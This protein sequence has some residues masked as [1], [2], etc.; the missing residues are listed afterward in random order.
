[1]GKKKDE[2]ISNFS[3]IKLICQ[4]IIKLKANKF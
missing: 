3:K 2:K 4:L 1:M